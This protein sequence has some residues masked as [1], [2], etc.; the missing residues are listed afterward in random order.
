M[1]NTLDPKLTYN[2]HTNNISVQAHTP[3]QMIK[4]TGCG[5][6]KLNTYGYL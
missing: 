5:K 6:Q 1:G 4:A 3:L 2:T